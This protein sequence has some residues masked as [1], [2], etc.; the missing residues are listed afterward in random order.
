MFPALALLG[1]PK[2]I[3]VPSPHEVW[4]P[5][6]DQSELDE[7]GECR[8]ASLSAPGRS[9]PVRLLEEA[10]SDFLE[11]KF[12]HIV[13]FNSGT[14]A[15]LAAYVGLGIGNGDQVLGPVLTYHAA[16]SPVFLLGGDVGLVDV[17]VG[18]RCIDPGRLEEAI[19]P[20]TKAVTVVHQWG[21]PADM[22]KIIPIVRKHRLRLIEDCSHAHGSRYKGQ[23]CGTFGDVAVFSLQA[24]KAIFAGEGG[25]LATNDGTIHTRATLLGHYRDRSRE[26][27]AGLPE[28][29]YWVTGYGQKLRMSPFNAVVARHSLR[30]YSERCRGRHQCLHYFRDRLK[31]V[32]FIE[33]PSVPQDGDMGAWYGFKPLIR[34]DRLPVSR[35]R[36]VEAL[37]AEGME[38]DAPSG[39]I[40]AKQ[41]LYCEEIDPVYRRQRLLP[42]FSPDQFPVAQLIESFALSLPTFFDP[43]IHLPIIDEYLETFKKVGHWAH[44][45]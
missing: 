39:G 32:T 34:P 38:V 18:S 3:K 43:K 9:G 2:E 23:L 5:Q 25:I 10:Y 24:K 45:L 26:E 8:D 11:N 30:L 36:L 6:A 29:R 15:L 21:H 19:T 12:R 13:T 37:K 17:E 31:E 35:E 44:L 20:Q 42:R 27:L 16:L 1:G 33:P 40:L 14:S 4:P 7:L 22:D 41:P 28:Q